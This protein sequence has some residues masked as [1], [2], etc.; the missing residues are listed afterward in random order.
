MKKFLTLIILLFILIAI[1]GF[2][3]LLM[4]DANQYK[5]LLTQK[6]EEAIDKDVR[7]GH[8]SL[9]FFP[10]LGLRVEDASIKERDKVWQEPLLKAASIEMSVR[11]LP[12][13]KKDIR[14][15]N[16]Y[17]RD[18][19]INYAG[20]VS[21]TPVN[22]KVDIIEAVFKNVSLYGPLG[23]E[24]RL[25]F[26]GR[27]AE[28]IKLKA[29][30]YPELKDK[31]PYIRNL[32]LRVALSKFDLAGALNALGDPDIAQQFIGKEIAGDLVISSEKIY[33]DP[34]N[35]YDSNVY[36]R[37]SNAMTD[38]LP[39]KSPI[40]NI[41]LT[42]EM[43][44]GN[45]TIQKGSGSIAGGS[46]L[47]KGVIEDMAS[48]QR[49]EMDITLRN[50]DVSMLLPEAAPGK[51]QL[52]GTLNI[53]LRSSSSG[54]TREGILDTLKAKGTV[55]LDRVVLKNMNVLTVALGKLNMLPGLMQRLRNRLPGYYKKLLREN[56]TAFKPI[57]AGFILENRKLFFQKVNVESDTFFLT[58]S[59]YLGINR[60]INVSS[61]LFIPQD[62][63]GAF[64][65]AVPEL[66]F[67]QDS[68]GMISMPLNISGRL[69]NVSVM[70]DL[71][72]VIQRLAVTKGQE[73]LE[74]ILKKGSPSKT[75]DES[76]PGEKEIRPEEVI[77][78]TIFDIIASPS[79][80]GNP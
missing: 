50:I 58:G 7:I 15:D 29:L 51:P 31:T 23:I 79:E 67:L 5:G 70:P 25:S 27:G 66:G 54:L 28:N 38:I 59:G 49:S 73:L 35:I 77:I 12:L 4:F 56:H 43:Y 17:I 16:L 53:A 69:P 61:Y 9:N 64:A 74:S 18:S 13:L 42:A 6:I 19:I 10:G 65:E 26:F 80:E 44:G 21:G 57:E 47:V 33:L 60:D 72:Y 32:T 55:K 63:S 36:V 11:L 48:L 37:L 39:I 3:F 46:F 8:I 34:K 62:L 45:I 22:L 24:A 30:L 1:A 2:V 40:K 68:Q 78:K 52:E 71:N 75:P 76:A 20:E 14:I 41:E